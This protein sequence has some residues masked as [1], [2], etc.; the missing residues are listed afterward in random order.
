M[1]DLT[2]SECIARKV[3]MVQGHQGRE[4]WFRNEHNNLKIKVH[5]ILINNIE[6]RYFVVMQSENYLNLSVNKFMDSF[7]LN[8]N[9]H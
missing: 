6:I 7:K 3:I 8:S 5:S 2:E 9:A 4:F 1:G